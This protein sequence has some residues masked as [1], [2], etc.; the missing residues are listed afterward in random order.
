[1]RN[2]IMT[3]RMVLRSSSGTLGKI[4]DRKAHQFDEETTAMTWFESS[5]DESGV[6]FVLKL[7]EEN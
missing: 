1:M 3:P 7:P 2:L 4:H 6:Q 5:M